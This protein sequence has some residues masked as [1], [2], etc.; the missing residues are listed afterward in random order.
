[1]GR[2]KSRLVRYCRRCTVVVAIG[3]CCSSTLSNPT[4]EGSSERPGKMDKSLISS[5]STAAMPKAHRYPFCV[6][7]I[8]SPKI[9]YP[10][11]ARSLGASYNGVLLSVLPSEAHFSLQYTQLLGPPCHSRNAN[12]L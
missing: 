12:G 8:P 3:T 7:E 4:M 2:R 10:K 1:M 11:D 5:V 6:L 9:V